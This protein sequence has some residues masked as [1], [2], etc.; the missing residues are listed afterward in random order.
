MATI[1]LITKTMDTIA[2]ICV[3]TGL[4]GL[5]WLKLDEIL[6]AIKDLKNNQPNG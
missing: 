3:I 5:V 4:T 6:D 2:L 1:N